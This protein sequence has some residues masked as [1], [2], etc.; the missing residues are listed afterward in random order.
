MS[1]GLGFMEGKQIPES[2]LLTPGYLTENPP[3]VVQ[4]PPDSHWRRCRGNQGYR[5]GSTSQSFNCVHI[6]Q[7]RSS[8]FQ[9]ALFLNTCCRTDRGSQCNKQ[10]RQG[11]PSVPWKDRPGR[12]QS[13]RIRLPALQLRL[14]SI[15]DLTRWS[16]ATNTNAV[17]HPC[18]GQIPWTEHTV[19]SHNSELHTF[20]IRASNPGIIA[21]L[22]LKGPCTGTKLP[23]LGPF[24]PDRHVNVETRP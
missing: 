14:L 17:A 6:S 20:D 15:A 16:S 4:S 23:S 2:Y 11:R 19:R 10:H 22:G 24:S 18:L 9:A 3:S 7:T 5:F 1:T 13:S 8:T 21:Y 12:T